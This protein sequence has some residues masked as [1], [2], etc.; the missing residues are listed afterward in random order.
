MWISLRLCFLSSSRFYRCLQIFSAETGEKQRKRREIQIWGI[1][2]KENLKAFL[3]IRKEFRRWLLRSLKPCQEIVPLMSQ[4]MERSLG[5]WDWLQ[6]RLHLIVCAWCKR[7][8][9]QIRFIRQLLREEME[10][11]GPRV[12]LGSEARERITH[13]IDRTS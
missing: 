6:V 9:N 7:Y 2:E 11:S 10:S 8:L 1:N 4:S 13:T 3:K 12:V 5:L